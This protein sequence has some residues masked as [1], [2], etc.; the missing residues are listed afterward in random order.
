MD[1]MSAQ[2]QHLIAEG[3]KAL[4]REIVVST[5]EMV[6]ED[7]LIDD[8]DQGWKDEDERPQGLRPSSRRLAQSGRRSLP[9]KHARTPSH[10]DSVY[11]T[12]QGRSLYDTSRSYSSIASSEPTRH[13][14]SPFQDSET[15]SRSSWTSP[16]TTYEKTPDLQLA[17]QRVKRAY[18]IDT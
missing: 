14:T 4:G 8:G 13:T 12:A 5:E 11:G 1:W 15:T 3:Q 10:P 9:S 16:E 17:M 18:G 2:L 6:T 7:D